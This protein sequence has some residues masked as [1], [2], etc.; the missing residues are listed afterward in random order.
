MVGGFRPFS[1]GVER[2]NDILM[3]LLLLVAETT[4][5]IKALLSEKIKF[6]W[7]QSQKFVIN[8]GMVYTRIGLFCRLYNIRRVLNQ[9]KQEK[10][11]LHSKGYL[12][13]LDTGYMRAFI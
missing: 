12:L 8:F 1:T 13:V 3:S 11:Y 9:T 2:H 7:E 5:K 4:N 10:T 6:T